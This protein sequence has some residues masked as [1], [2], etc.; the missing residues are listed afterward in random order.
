MLHR[1]ILKSKAVINVKRQI[2][3]IF[4]GI[5]F[6][7]SILVL[8]KRKKIIHVYCKEEVRHF[9]PLELISKHQI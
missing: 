6:G 2:L 9:N 8:I 7:S 5:S 1:Q 3:A 4:Y